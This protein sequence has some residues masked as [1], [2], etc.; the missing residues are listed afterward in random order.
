VSEQVSGGTHTVFLAGVH[1]G[2]GRPG[3]P[4]AYYRG[5]YGRLLLAQDTPEAVGEVLEARATIEIGVAATLLGRLTPEQ[6]AE[7]REL[8]ASAGELAFLDH[9]VALTGNRA[10]LEAYRRLDLPR[11]L[12]A[13]GETAAALLEA[14][15]RGDLDAAIAAIRARQA[16]G[17]GSG[18]RSIPT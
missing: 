17:A 2:S 7:S 10:L 15:E 1:R 16:A 11:T 8:L 6:L 3:S 9:L 14:C 12:A 13:G 18:S 5:Q 4:L